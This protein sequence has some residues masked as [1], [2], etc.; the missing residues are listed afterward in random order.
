MLDFYYAAGLTNFRASELARDTAPETETE[1]ETEAEKEE[2][3]TSA[4]IKTETNHIYVDHLPSAEPA[5]NLKP[6]KEVE[7]RV[8]VPVPVDIEAGL[9]FY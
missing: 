3:Q 7:V 2:T 8:Q 5:E 4:T 6:E 1:T 9:P